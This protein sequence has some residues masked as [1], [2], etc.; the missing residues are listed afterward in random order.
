[1]NQFLKDNNIQAEDVWRVALA[2]GSCSIPYIGERIEKMF[3]GKV[4]SDMD[5]STLVAMG[6]YTVAASIG[7]GMTTNKPKISDIL[8]H[9]L[10]VKAD[11]AFSE[12]LP[13]YSPYPLTYT[14]TFTTSKNNQKSVSIEI[15]ETKDM[16]GE[17]KR[18]LANCELLGLFT[19]SNIRKAKKGEVKIDVT[20]EYDDSRILKVTARDQDTGATQDLII[21]YDKKEIQRKL[22]ETSFVEP[23]NIFFAI[24]ASGSMGGSKMNNTKLAA[25]NLIE[26]VIDLSI[27]K[28]GIV[29][30]GINS[31][32][33]MECKLT[34][35]KNQ[36]LTAVDSLWAYGGTPL[37]EALEMIDGE[38]QSGENNY[39]ICLTDGMPN[40]VQKSY[41]AADQLK[42]HGVTILSVGAGISGDANATN[43]LKN[44]SS[45]RENGTPFLWLTDNV[46]EISEIFEQIIGEIS[47][48]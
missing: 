37:A 39:V 30:F 11:N 21:E 48:M 3:P 23:M 33:R 45:Q 7:G 40:S 2:G 16:G 22:D 43:V 34:H 14:K 1:M 9:S 17:D 19:L 47:E 46:N 12:M 28:A 32:A 8:S 13:R 20:F 27:H 10:G 35:N 24:D 5:L 36:L 44:I 38:F 42:N 15:Y 31:V 26:N 25:R 29:S 4:F 41:Q 6:A 18:N